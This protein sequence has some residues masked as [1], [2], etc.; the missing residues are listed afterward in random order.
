MSVLESAKHCRETKWSARTGTTSV[1]NY[2]VRDRVLFF[3]SRMRAQRSSSSSWTP[4][5]GSASVR[6]EVPL[7]ARY[8]LRFPSA[9]VAEAPLNTNHQTD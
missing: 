9:F 4:T 8:V 1:R 5:I 7:V 2:D 3:L 6:F